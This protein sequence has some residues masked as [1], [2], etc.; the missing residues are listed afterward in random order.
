MAKKIVVF[1]FDGTITKYDTTRIYLF[2]LFL[3]F[4]VQSLFLFLKQRVYAE[5]FSSFFLTNI[6]RKKKA[7]VLN[8]VIKVYRIICRKIINEKILSLLKV[9]LDKRDYLV[10]IATASPSVFV[11]SI[12]SEIPLIAYNLEIVN[13]IFTGK[14]KNK[15]PLG[16]EK[17]FQVKEFMINNDIMILDSVYSDSETDLPLLSAAQ[18]AYLVNGNSITKLNFDKRK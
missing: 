12:L 17:F 9:Y 15:R 2:L 14:E 1:D 10:I 8:K 6:L 4:P 7:N 5:S 11:Q 3:R 13:G 18:N 16:E